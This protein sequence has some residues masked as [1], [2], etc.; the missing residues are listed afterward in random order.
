[1]RR[2]AIRRRRIAEMVLLVVALCATSVA[3]AGSELLVTQ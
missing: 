2:R 1:V 3:F